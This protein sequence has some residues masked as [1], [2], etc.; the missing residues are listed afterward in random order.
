M[1]IKKTL[2]GLL[3]F[4][5][6]STYAQVNIDSLL[7]IWNDPSQQDTSRLEAINKISW[8]GYLFT[9]PDSAYYFSEKQLEFARERNLTKYI[10]LALSTQG[11]YFYFQGDYSKALERHSEC[12]KI[13]E[14]IG[15]KLGMAK[16]LN[17]IGLVYKRRGDPNKALD[18]Y[19][20]GLKIK[21]EFGDKESIAA[22]LNNIGNI[23]LDQ[24]D[25]A[26]AIDYYSKSLKLIEQIGDKN[27]IAARLNN[28]GNIYLETGEYNL[29]H[30]YYSKSLKIR[31][32][33]GNNKD[34]S[35]SLN[36]LGAVYKNQGDYSNALDHLFKSLNIKEE[37]RDKPGIAE[38]LVNIG[39]IY[40]LQG[41]LDK[42]LGNFSKSF[43]ISE[44]IGEKL[45]MTSSLNS[46]GDIYYDKGNYTQASKYNR[47]SLRIAQ[48]I[49]AKLDI[50]HASQSLWKGYRELGQFE[51]A[52]KMHELFAQTRY[53][54]NTEET[55][56]EIIQQR[57]KYEYGKKVIADS[58]AFL[59][60]QEITN[61]T[62][63]EQE[64]QIKFSRYF[65]LLLVT[66]LVFGVLFILILF[67]NNKRVRKAH[68]IIKTQKLLVDDTNNKLS[69]K[70]IEIQEQSER[71]NDA[72]EEIRV[73]NE[74]LE[75]QVKERTK[76]IESQ[77]TLLREYTFS[78]S[79]EIRAPLARLLG[80]ISVLELENITQ[81]EQTEIFE[82]ILSSAHELDEIL[83]SVSDML[84]KEKMKA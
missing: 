53:S 8:N 27:G 75:N 2:V 35:A 58:V 3:L 20:R 1:V 61:L 60:Q 36:N 18:Y 84:S 49:G 14:D 15:D 7:A 79:H 32:E 21:V 80:L 62:I 5:A 39:A 68:L 55:Q 29:A 10:T 19:T 22:S 83:K 40:H 41:E 45:L 16:S 42:A 50:Q 4:T 65:M 9:Q 70:N 73:I 38:V 37:I 17:N 59:K 23:Y 56:K 48:E 67:R 78:I 6:T 25:Y 81:D 71:I 44:E 66:I 33:I 52:L 13:K 74:S 30:D 77:N 51:E 54:I 46:I 28:I 12:L 72:H 82:N 64:A 34:I 47:Q 26:T 69:K 43:Q 31:E 24:G 76:K 11:A 63:S 57:Y